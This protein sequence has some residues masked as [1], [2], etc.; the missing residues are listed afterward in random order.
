MLIPD[1]A[2]YVGGSFFCP[3][4]R[5]QNIVGGQAQPAAYAMPSAVRSP[6]PPAPAK[7]PRHVVVLAV[8]LVVAFIG[9]FL[10]A[11]SVI[12]GLAS[13]AIAI[14]YVARPDV[15]SGVDRVL[16]LSQSSRV[17]SVARAAVVGVWGVVGLI[18]FPLW[19]SIDRELD[20]REAAEALEVNQA[21]EKRVAAAKRAAETEAAAEAEAKRV[22]HEQELAANATKAATDFGTTMDAVE[23][24]IVAENWP[25]AETALSRIA[26]P[27]A[28]YREL[29]NN[30]LIMTD[31]IT[32]YDALHTRI[33][34][35]TR[36]FERAAT[37]NSEL[38]A[39]LDLTEGTKDGKA[40]KTAKA[41]W[42]RAAA[43]ADELGKVTGEAAKY[44][45]NN[46]S[47]L[48]KNIEKCLK[49]AEKIV[50]KYEND[51]LAMTEVATVATMLGL[52]PAA[53]RNLGVIAST[54]DVSPTTVGDKAAKA[55]ELCLG[56]MDAVGADPRT[57]IGKVEG[58][59]EFVATVV[60]DPQT[61]KLIALDELFVTYITLGCPDA[62]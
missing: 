27:I 50:E 38:K 23:S 30:P 36:V 32:R 26:D 12:V 60:V 48:R 40:W 45:P 37:L 4:C 49:G 1:Q 43:E 34:A 61:G 29:K 54:L 20:R 47:T 28:E 44:V 62:S 5:A 6:T 58:S 53:R 7:T 31:A 13:V 3:N 46:L 51:E 16:E 59:L 8:L 55:S 17:G 15:Q 2:A 42:E 24:E 9:T 11:L 19:L 57:A 18:G 33:K 22:A 21:E 39:G 52:S 35:V 14:A 10:P 56:G 41:H 25:K